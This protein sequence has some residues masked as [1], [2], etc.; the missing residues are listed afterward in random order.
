MMIYTFKLF[1]DFGGALQ[2]SFASLLEKLKYD[3]AMSFN[4]VTS[5][6]VETA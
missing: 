6:N 4:D 5:Y 2:L 3:D 1:Q